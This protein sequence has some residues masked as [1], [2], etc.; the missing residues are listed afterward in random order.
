MNIKVMFQSS[1]GAQNALAN[2][3]FVTIA[4]AVL[5]CQKWCEI[6]EHKAYLWDGTIWRQ[7]AYVP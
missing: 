7:Y 5:A 3:E 6:A 1:H 4:D 2:S